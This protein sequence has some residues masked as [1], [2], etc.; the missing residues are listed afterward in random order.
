M[1]R[2]KPASNEIPWEKLGVI[3]GLVFGAHSVV[4]IAMEAVVVVATVESFFARRFCQR[5]KMGRRR[6]R[7]EA[8]R[9][10]GR[11]RLSLVRSQLRTIETSFQPKFKIERNRSTRSGPDQGGRAERS[12][13]TT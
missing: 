11:R 3:F 6:R 10:A 2:G 12:E 5:A 4:I 8:R 7:G 9:G 13:A 1:R